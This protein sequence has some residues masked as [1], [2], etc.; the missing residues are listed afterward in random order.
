[1]IVGV[2]FGDGRETVRIGF[3]VEFTAID[4]DAAETCAVASEEFSGRVYHDIG[5]VLDG[6]H[7][8]GSAESIV[9]NQRNTV[10]VSDFGQLVDISYIGIRIAE[11]LGK[12][13]LRFGFYR[14]LDFGRI[15][16]VDKSRGYASC[17]EC[18]GKKVGGSAVEV[19]GGDNMVTVL[20]NI[21]EGIY[22]S[23]CSTCDGESR[24]AAFE[25][26]DTLLKDILGRVGETAI[27]IAGLT[28]S[29]AVGGIGRILEHIRRG[30]IDR[31]RA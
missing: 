11:G 17:R 2:R 4:Y 20:S 5:T 10:S 6:S 27:D 12:Q 21:L 18:V 25:C 28:Q 31:H 16:N 9:D 8:V 29:E 26:G 3:P 1:M 15:V 13:G 30:L 23:G 7:Q 22:D 24:N 14:S 19:V